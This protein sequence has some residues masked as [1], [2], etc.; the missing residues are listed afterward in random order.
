MFKYPCIYAVA[1]LR[2][3]FGFACV[4]HRIPHDAR[5][6]PWPREPIYNHSPFVG[7]VLFFVVVSGGLHEAPRSRDLGDYGTAVATY[8]VQRTDGVSCCFSVAELHEAEPAGG[9]RGRIH[10][11]DGL[12]LGQ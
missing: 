7:Q 2:V 4:I 5:G 8:A 6:F 3:V 10:D 11:D 1:S 9:T 12:S